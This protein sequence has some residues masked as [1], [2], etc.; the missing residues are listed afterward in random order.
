M[1]DRRTALRL[2]R[3]LVDVVVQEEA[4]GRT[5]ELELREF[6]NLVAGHEELNAVLT[7][8]AVSVDHKHALIKAL[9]SQ[10]SGASPITLS[11]LLLLAE[12]DLQSLLPNLVEMYHERLME[13]MKVVS[14]EVTTAIPLV[15]DR[16]QEI[17]KSLERMTGRQIVMETRVDPSL[18]GGVITKIGSVVYDGSVSQQLAKLKQQLVEG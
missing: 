3:A 6:Q 4:N 15:E 17:V 9:L 18:I 11:V 5:I 8:P 13:Q 12:R 7:N 10:K 16:E 14:A 1:S 2:A